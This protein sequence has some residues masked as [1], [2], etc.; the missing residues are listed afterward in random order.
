T[1]GRPGTSPRLGVVACGLGE[2]VERLLAEGGAQVVPSGP[3]RRASAGQLLAA[4]WATGARR[5][6][7]LPNDGDT[8]MVAMAV[9]EAAA[10][11]GVAVDVVPSRTLVQG[12][13]AVAVLAPEGEADAVV[14]SMTEAAEA[15]RP[16]ALTRAER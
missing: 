2:G 6:V 11:D 1:T 15:V 16:G 4:V 12:L 9:A 14:A 3:R 7:L 5:V 13:A 8:V 10:Q